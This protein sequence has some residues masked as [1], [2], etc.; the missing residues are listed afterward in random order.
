MQKAADTIYPVL[1]AIAKRWS[2]RSFDRARHLS[3]DDLMSL[4]EAA[5]WAASANN[6]QPWRFVYARR[7]DAAFNTILS[8]LEPGNALWA[9]RAGM[10]CIA[11]AQVQREDGATNKHA[12]HDLGQSLANLALQATS[13]GLAAH[14]MAG[15][16]AGRARALLRIPHGFEP[17]TVV[18]VGWVARPEDLPSDNLRQ[19]ELA[20]RSR[21]SIGEFAFAGQWAN[22]ASI[23][24]HPRKGGL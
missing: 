24:S 1:P 20:P 22:S 18:A 13:M 14:Q 5:R 4:F 12:I 16:D 6:L 11:I 8:C 9:D 2:P 21:R 23:A 7:E 10:L 3:R 17:V 19:R 15:F